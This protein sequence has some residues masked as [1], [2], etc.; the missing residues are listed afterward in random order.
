MI[1]FGSPI[2][3]GKTD[4]LAR[5]SGRHHVAD[6]DLAVGDD[7]PVDQEFDERTLLLKRGVGQSMLYSGAKRG[8]VAWASLKLG[9]PYPRIASD[10]ANSGRFGDADHSVEDL[11]GDGD[12]TLLAIG[13]PS[14]ELRTDDV[15]VATDG[16]FEGLS[17]LAPAAGLATIV[18]RG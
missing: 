5:W 4:L 17:D 12:F 11:D 9:W 6:L 8:V 16:R 14:S 3:N 15:L 18:W 10:A 1:L 2:A 7:H 13:W